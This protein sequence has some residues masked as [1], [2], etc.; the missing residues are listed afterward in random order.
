M[1]YFLIGIIIIVVLILIIPIR[2]K[3]KYN[4]K[5]RKKSDNNNILD[6]IISQ[7][8]SYTNENYMIVYILYFIPV[9]KIRLDKKKNSKKSARKKSENKLR[10]KIIADD[11]ITTILNF[12]KSIINY[13][14]TNKFYFNTKD[15]K[16]LAK[17]LKYKK[18]DINFEINF[19]EPIINSYVIAFLNSIINIYIAKNINQF[20]LNKTTYTTYISNEIYSLRLNMIMSVSIIMILPIIIK[21]LIKYFILKKKINNKLK[22]NVKQ[23]NQSPQMANNLT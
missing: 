17:H 2:V 22:N 7:N 15:A 8:D 18:L 4:I 3:L 6:D 20:N 14:K 12:L 19:F 10:K 5:H 13:E 21:A 1:W 16:S 9:L 11:V 23:N